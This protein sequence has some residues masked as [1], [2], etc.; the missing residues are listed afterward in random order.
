M[1]SNKEKL[2]D[3][4]KS[5]KCNEMVDYISVNIVSRDEKGILHRECNVFGRTE[6]DYKLRGYLN[7]FDD[8]LRFNLDK[9]VMIVSA[10]SCSNVKL[11]GVRLGYTF[12]VIIS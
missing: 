10:M 9:D 12:K 1:L 8:D 4:F 11:E 5:A 3:L 7:S 2:I 6:F